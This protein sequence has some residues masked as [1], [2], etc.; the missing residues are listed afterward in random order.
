MGS[1]PEQGLSWGGRGDQQHRDDFLTSGHEMFR[2]TEQKIVNKEF[3][4]AQSLE[5]K[6]LGICGIHCHFPGSL[7]HCWEFLANM[8]SSHNLPS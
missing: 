2:V 4:T 6:I 8:V 1:A 7:S 5:P 3:K